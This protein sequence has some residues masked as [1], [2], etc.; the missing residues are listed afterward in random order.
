HEWYDTPNIHLCTIADFV[1]LAKES[2][3]VIERALALDGRGR[4]QPM[5]A[6]AWGPNLLADGAIFLLR[7]ARD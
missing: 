5:R 2:G 6:E 1:S 4:S 3:A 7:G